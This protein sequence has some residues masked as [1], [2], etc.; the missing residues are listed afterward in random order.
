MSGHIA[1]LLNGA[2]RVSHEDSV[3]QTT[4]AAQ[5]ETLVP[6]DLLIQVNTLLT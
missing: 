2:F 1:F 3:L 6:A 5:T 4:L